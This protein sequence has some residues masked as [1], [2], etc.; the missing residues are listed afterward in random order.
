MKFA[1]VHQH[2]IRAERTNLGNAIYERLGRSYLLDVAEESIRIQKEL[3]VPWLDQLP[4][5]TPLEKSS[6][7]L[8]VVGS[9]IL[10]AIRQEGKLNLLQLMR[11]EI[12]PD[13]NDDDMFELRAIDDDDEIKDDGNDAT[14]DKAAAL[15]EPIPLEELVMVFVV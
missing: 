8:N 15:F 11:R 14:T 7:G 1:A 12:T 3:N 4:T 13:V 10:G 6:G 2:N 5:P 9:M